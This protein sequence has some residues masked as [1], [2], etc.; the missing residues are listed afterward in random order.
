MMKG[1][2]S[3][4]CKNCV[5]KRKPKFQDYQNC[6]KASQVINAVNYL[7]KKLMQIILEKIK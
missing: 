6:L 7:E 2:K 1:K 3:K 4:R 5:I